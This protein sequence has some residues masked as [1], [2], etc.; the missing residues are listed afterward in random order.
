MIGST[1]VSMPGREMKVC[2]LGRK[3][4]VFIQD[5]RAKR[6]AVSEQLLLH[7]IAH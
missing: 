1:L 5:K 7:P 3:L 4:Q 6:S 2:F